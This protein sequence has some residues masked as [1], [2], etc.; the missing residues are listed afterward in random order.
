MKKQFLNTSA[1]DKKLSLS[2]R[3]FNYSSAFVVL[4]TFSQ[5]GIAQSPA[6]LW[7]K[8][9]GGSKDELIFNMIKLRDGNYLYCG[10]TNSP[11][12]DFNVSNKKF[13]AFLLKTNSTGIVIWK[14]TYGGSRNE[15]F[16]NIIETETG[17]IIA[18]GTTGS[19]NSPV[20]GHHGNPG[21][22]DVWL[23]RTSSAGVLINQRCFGGSGSEGTPDLGECQG[24]IIDHNGNILFTAQSNSNDGD[25][26]NNHGDYDGWV[27]KLKPTFQVEWAITIGDAAYDNM[28]NISEINGFYLVTGTK[29]T[30]SYADFPNV[31]DYFKAHAAKIDQ[32][33]N[34]IWY[35]IYGGSGSDDCNSS[36]ASSDGNLVLT[37]HAFSTDGDCVSNSGFNTWTWKINVNNGVIMWQNYT[38]GSPTDT[39]AAFNIISTRDGGFIV[40][41][42][43]GH[44]FDPIGFDAY[45]VKLDANGITQ[46]TKRFGGSGV[47]GMQ[48]GVEANNGSILIAGWTSSNDADVSGNHGG[49]DGWLVSLEE[50]TNRISN[51][52]VLTKNKPVLTNAL[53]TYPNPISSS[54]T[55]IYSIPQS[56]KVSLKIVDIMGRPI[57]TLVNGEI[58][59]GS[60]N[61]QWNVDDEKGRSVPTG[62]YFLRMEGGDYLQTKKLIVTK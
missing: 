32:S 35:R 23:V 62:I 7:Q 2:R 56:T 3:L 14:T 4:F 9:I 10:Q 52:S 1:A 13:D 41:G 15:I 42:F 60:Y 49:L 31:H 51:K 28:Y 50:N 12:G 44:I 5:F 26:S 25:I 30:K 38:G 45:A 55:I 11:D 8:C 17:D 6:I 37:G 39:A 36:V 47:E 29:A 59:A 53:K 21:T 16:Y 19:N 58:A 24:L 43:I 40:M 34:I 48:C 61:I 57:K 22:D 46:Y 27:V 20:Q 33:G 18:I 54:V